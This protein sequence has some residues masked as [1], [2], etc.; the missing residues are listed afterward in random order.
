VTAFL[1]VDELAVRVGATLV[2]RNVS[3][4]ANRGGKVALVGETGSGKSMTCR[5][6]IGLLARVGATPVSGRVRLGDTDLLQLRE[7]EWRRV[8]GHRIGFIPQASLSSLNPVR[9][10]GFHLD[11]AV[12]TLCHRGTRPNPR[13][14]LE[15]VRLAD[16]ERVLRQYPHELS[17][18]M[19]QRVMI[20]L[21]LVGSPELLVADEPTTALDATTQRSILTLLLRICT[22]HEMT[23]L[24]VTHDLRTAELVADSIAVM[25]A[26]ETVEFGPAEAV[27]RE[28]KHDYT[29]ALLR[30]APT[31]EPTPDAPDPPE[32]LP[33]EH[34]ARGA[35]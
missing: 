13:Q 3:F 7:R 5:T 19:R 24:M 1:E 14:L 29:R 28:P 9:T 30:A 16:P 4:T 32:P 26:G 25:Y 31:L 22:E 12:T 23:L 33:R 10:I 21:A 20:A 2:L 27:L 18:G 17:G 15:D 8:R 35:T 34:F 11:E 6:L